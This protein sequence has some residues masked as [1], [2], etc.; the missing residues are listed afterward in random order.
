MSLIG[1]LNQLVFAALGM[2]LGW[3]TG[4]WMHALWRRWHPHRIRFWG[5]WYTD[6]RLLLA[7]GLALVGTWVGLLFTS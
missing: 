3:L 5:A 6:P 4:V 2:A 7:G 1:I